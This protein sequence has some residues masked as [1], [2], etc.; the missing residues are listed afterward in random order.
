MSRD[1]S[2]QPVTTAPT[3][4]KFVT[5]AAYGVNQAGP[6]RSCSALAYGSRSTAAAEKNPHTEDD[7]QAH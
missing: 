7:N 6:R 4:S 5:N 3:A 2:L 1:P